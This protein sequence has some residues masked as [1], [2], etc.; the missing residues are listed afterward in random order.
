MRVV[1]WEN[2]TREA[3]LPSV[4]TGEAF[5]VAHPPEATEARLNLDQLDQV[6]S[7]QFGSWRGTG[8]G[9]S[10]SICHFVSMIR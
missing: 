7:G 6:A 3:P 1:S 2:T 10:A 9:G 5:S 8:C 4:E